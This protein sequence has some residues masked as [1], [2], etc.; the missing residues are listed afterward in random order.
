METMSSTYQFLLMR[1]Q[2]HLILSV[3][4]GDTEVLLMSYLSLLVIKTNIALSG[5]ALAPEALNGRDI[6]GMCEQ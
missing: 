6:L 3:C 5:E 4:Y 1:I 2:Q